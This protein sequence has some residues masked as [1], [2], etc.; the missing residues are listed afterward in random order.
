MNRYLFISD[1][2]MGTNDHVDNFGDEKE[3]LFKRLIDWKNKNKITK[4]FVL[5][6]IWELWQ[7][8]GWKEKTR[9]K[10]AK[11]RYSY[12]NNNIKHWTKFAGNHDWCTIRTDKYRDDLLYAPENSIDST[13]MISHGHMYD[14]F[15]DDEVMSGVSRVA[16]ELWGIVEKKIGIER[17]KK[18]MP[19]IDN[20]I[21][22]LKMKAKGN[23]RDHNA[24][25]IRDVAVKDAEAHVAKFAIVGHTHVPIVEKVKCVY[26][27][28]T[29]TWTDDRSDIVIID[30]KLR[31]ILNVPFTKSFA[32]NS[33][34]NQLKQR[35]VDYL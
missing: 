32:K 11:K 3:E 27:I 2:H 6:D 35:G 34:T 30:T 21:E 18:Y 23:G 16:T 25:V 28:N 4:T 22:R 7:G 20:Y 9:L 29:G 5:G 17:T 24:D 10:L 15:F 13:M 1:L 8:D 31:K 19:T 26:Y 14:P 12:I 33:L